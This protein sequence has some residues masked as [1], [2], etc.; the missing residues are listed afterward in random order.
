[1]SSPRIISLLPSATEIVCALGFQEHL[2]GRSHECDYPE[3]VEQLPICSRPKLNP[4]GT[5]YQIDERVKAIVQEGLSVYR[6]DGEKLKTLQPDIIVTQSQCEVCAVSTNELQKALKRFTDYT[7]EIVDQQPDSLEDIFDDIKRVAQALEVPD[8]GEHLVQDLKNIMNKVTSTTQQIK[9][10]PRVVC[11]EWLNPLMTAGN[12]MP[13]LIEKAGGHNLLS[14]AGKHS[15][16][17]EW[18]KV[19]ENNPD[20]LLLSPCGFSI[21]QTLDNMRDLTERPGWNELKAVRNNQV[22]ITDGHH[23][24]NRPGPRIVDTVKM[25]AEIFHPEHHS[26]GFKRKG[27]ISYSSAPSRAL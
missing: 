1:M 11:L 9:N 10:K 23:Y 17:V 16:Y 12:W 3:G 13:T 7:P 15:G 4:D 14:E 2:V 20:I 27:W 25:M 6:I 8:R 18:E 26:F 22:Y 19:V 21:Q 24:F 5:S